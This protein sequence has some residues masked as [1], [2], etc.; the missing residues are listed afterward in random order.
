M[1]PTGLFMTVGTFVLPVGCRASKKTSQPSFRRLCF[2]YVASWAGPRISLPFKILSSTTWTN[3]PEKVT[4]TSTNPMPAVGS[5]IRVPRFSSLALAKRPKHSCASFSGR[6][7]NLPFDRESQ[8]A[9]TA[10]D[11]IACLK[12]S[13]N[14]RML[15]RGSLATPLPDA[16]TLAA[17]A[18]ETKNS[19]FF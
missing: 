7:F 6:F 2:M 8:N 5:R 10:S 9:L 14:L 19:L 15:I 4:R 18:F 1:E 11:S 12:A 16:S 3:P 17:I 13:R